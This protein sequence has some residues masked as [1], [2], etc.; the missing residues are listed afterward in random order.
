METKQDIIY[1]CENNSDKAFL[2]QYTITSGSNNDPIK[3]NALSHLTEHFLI[4]LSGKSKCSEYVIHGFTGFYYTNYYWYTNN[5]IEAEESFQEFDAVI[6]KSKEL[7][8]DEKL[9]IDTKKEIEEEIIFYAKKNDSLLQI[10]STLMDNNKIINLPIGCVDD[11]RNITFEDLNNYLREKYIPTNVHKFIIGKNNEIKN[12]TNL[13]VHSI[14]NQ[15]CTIPSKIFRESDVQTF[16]VSFFSRAMEENSVKILFRDIFTDSLEEI[17][18]GEIFMMQICEFSQKVM[19]GKV[20]VT[21]EIIFIS[22]NDIYY[23]LTLD[24]MDPNDYTHILESRKVPIYHILSTLL[25]KNGFDKL[26]N[27]I[28]QYL[29]KYNRKNV[30]RREI[31]M[32]LINY[33]TLSFDSYNVINNQDKLISFIDKLDFAKYQGFVMEKVFSNTEE[34]IKILY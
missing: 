26:S 14:Q 6:K 22:K 28:M 27:S 8:I 20:N 21:Y 15:L 31:M 30:Q 16:N 29:I 24:N 1:I 23:A 34:I 5:I 9:F 32:D 33:V 7:P 18:L 2:C 10:I 13:G 17:I 4:H 3:K 25:D 11:V 12:I 19:N